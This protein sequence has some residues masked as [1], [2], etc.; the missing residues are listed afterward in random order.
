MATKPS[1]L[2]LILSADYQ[3][4]DERT[5]EPLIFKSQLI[6]DYQ[7]EDKAAFSIT[8]RHLLSLLFPYSSAYEVS[9]STVI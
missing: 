6:R 8:R 1:M 4:S 7:V 3:Q 5:R 2:T 9:Q